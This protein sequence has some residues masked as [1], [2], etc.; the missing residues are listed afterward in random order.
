MYAPFIIWSKSTSVCLNLF[1]IK[2]LSLLRLH[3]SE[4]ETPTSIKIADF[5]QSPHS[6]LFFFFPF[7]IAVEVETTW[8]NMWRDHTL[9]AT[10][11]S[12][13]N[14]AADYLVAV[15]YTAVA[16]RPSPSSA[17]IA[18]P[19]HLRFSV[20]C[21]AFEA[22]KQ[23]S[24]CRTLW[25][26]CGTSG[27]IT[28]C[29]LVYFGVLSQSLWAGFAVV[30]RFRFAHWQ[31]GSHSGEALRR[32]PDSVVV[33]HGTRCM[34]GDVVYL[35]GWQI[36]HLAV[37]AVV[38]WW[39]EICGVALKLGFKGT[40]V[41]LLK[42][43]T[44]FVKVLVCRPRLLWLEGQSRLQ[45]EILAALVRVLQLDWSGVCWVGDV[46]RFIAGGVCNAFWFLRQC[47]H[48]A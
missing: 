2:C 28:G 10:L 3:K 7:F 14:H 25:F 21:G 44:A 29:G 36:F 40:T 5:T 4:I 18:V 45:R 41:E 32:M 17:Q 39:R 37:N 47:E 13:R 26:L 11:V 35:E 46:I 33:R 43:I 20:L 23:F 16:I 27:G 9:S 12:G 24:V 6:W 31:S 48:V 19:V 38:C 15:V 22:R 42:K 34:A 1:P 8:G 30:R